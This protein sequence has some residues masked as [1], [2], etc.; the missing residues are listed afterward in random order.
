MDGQ[1]FKARM[2]VKSLGNSKYEILDP[3]QYLNSNTE[4]QNMFVK[5]EFGILFV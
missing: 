2:P 3:K 1:G 5:F 4:I